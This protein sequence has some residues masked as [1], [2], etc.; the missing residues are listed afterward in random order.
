MMLSEYLSLQSLGLS[1]MPYEG[2]VTRFYYTFR[3]NLNGFPPVNYT[4][5][6]L[7]YQPLLKDGTTWYGPIDLPNPSI[8]FTE[9]TAET[10]AGKYY[11]MKAVASLPGSNMDV[12]VNLDNLIHHQFIIAVK[13][14]SGSY[15]SVYGNNYGGC[16]FDF[17]DGTGEGAKDKAINRLTWTY[18][19][20]QR[21]YVLDEFDGN[22]SQSPF[23]YTPNSANSASPITVPSYAVMLTKLSG[24]TY[25]I[26]FV[27]ADE[28]NGGGYPAVY[29]Y[30][31][32]SLIR[33]VPQGPIE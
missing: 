22:A 18:E 10:K 15:W 29:I 8:G 25:Q 30:F 4:T 3:E 20:A 23:L 1:H 12:H 24:S 5:Q 2:G 27:E 31:N 17:E 21:S 13:R 19:S 9:T 26:F 33:L 11:K 16:S 32:N 6:R 7:A 14:R 28:E